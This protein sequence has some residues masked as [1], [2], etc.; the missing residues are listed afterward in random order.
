MKKIFIFSFSVILLILLGL[1]F[2]NTST[3]VNLSLQ[4]TLNK[5]VSNL[6]LNYTGLID[7]FNIQ[8]IDPNDTLKLKIK[9]NKNFNEGSMKIYYLNDN[10]EKEEFYIIGYFEKGYKGTLHFKIIEEDN[11]L[12]IVEIK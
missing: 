4:N 9:M 3:T 1:S 12:K 6:K 11:K 7:D 2:F 8:T 10:G 5:P